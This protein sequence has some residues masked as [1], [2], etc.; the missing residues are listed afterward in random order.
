M[1]LILDALKQADRERKI[2]HAPDLAPVLKVKPEAS[3]RSRI[4]LCLCAAVL[5]A[6]VIFVLLFQPERPKQVTGPTSEHPRDIRPRNSARPAGEP[7]AA[8]SRSNVEKEKIPS[9]RIKGPLPDK[10]P[11]NP[12]RE[13]LSDSSRSPRSVQAPARSGLPEENPAAATK[14]TVRTLM[15][16]ATEGITD[17]RPRGGTEIRE[18]IPVPAAADS[19]RVIPLV[20][21]LQPE[22][23]GSLGE[24]E[25]SAHVFDEEP[26]K[27][28]VFINQRSYRTGDRIGENG[29]TLKE[30]TPDG[31]VIDYGKGQARLQIR[32]P[33]L[34]SE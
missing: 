15:K 13:T 5:A 14:S 20:S 6:G 2:T 7:G 24:L 30:I 4:G 12:G 34:W 10:K 19:E 25:I 8:L 21:E 32:R 11:P 28:F 27:R 18:T 33:G 16:E 23:R 31:I 1:S 9:R 22:V 3:P 26:A 29:P 17:D